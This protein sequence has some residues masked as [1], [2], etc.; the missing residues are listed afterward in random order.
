VENVQ[1]RLI[2]I[3]LG[4]AHSFYDGM[5]PAS[6]VARRIVQTEIGDNEL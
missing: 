1:A 3:S 4:A 5:T 6:T 2:R